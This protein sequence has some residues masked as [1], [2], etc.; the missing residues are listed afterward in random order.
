MKT[1]FLVYTNLDDLKDPLRHTQINQN[2]DSTRKEY[3][4]SLR[5]KSLVTGLRRPSP[6]G[7]SY[8][9]VVV[10]TRSIS[11]QLRRSAQPYDSAKLPIRI[12]DDDDPSF[13]FSLDNS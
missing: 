12:G 3:R 1:K 10:S 11:A 8:S 13:V 2:I 5:P 9:T 4:F 7:L 6:R